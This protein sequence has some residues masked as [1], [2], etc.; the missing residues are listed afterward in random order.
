MKKG[1]GNAYFLGYN[2]GMHTFCCRRLFLQHPRLSAS[3]PEAGRDSGKRLQ[4]L[5]NSVASSARA[6]C[7]QPLR[8]LRTSAEVYLIRNEGWNH[9]FGSAFFHGRLIPVG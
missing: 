6:A 4:S 8:N 3:A 7:V 5:H 9:S 1:D 2:D